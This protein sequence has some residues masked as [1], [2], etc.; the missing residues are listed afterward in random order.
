MISKKYNRC[1]IFKKKSPV[2]L[3]IRLLLLFLL[4]SVI[5]TVAWVR[6]MLF[7]AGEVQGRILASNSLT[8][9]MSELLVSENSMFNDF[10]KV[11]QDDN[12]NVIGLSTDGHKAVSLQNA[13]SDKITR[14]LSDGDGRNYYVPLGTLLGSGFLSGRGPNISLRILPMGHTS[15]ELTTEFDTT[16]I[17]QS[18]LSVYLNISMEYTLMLPMTSS[19][20]VVNER[21]LVAQTT[22]VG[23]VPQYLVQ[24]G[25]LDKQGS[26]SNFSIALPSP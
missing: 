16:G 11:L 15:V 1:T 18:T 19:T 25:S 4:V 6:P 14:M 9:L 26:D 5:I 24:S 21:Y 23:K 3:L 12:G 10:V 8:A 17:N 20:N 2:G 22:V 13:F 7:R